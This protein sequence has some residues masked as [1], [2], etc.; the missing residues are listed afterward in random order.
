MS[1]SRLT[2][3]VADQPA[4]DHDVDQS[5]LDST[6]YRSAAKGKIDDFK[7]NKDLLL[8]QLLT[9]NKNTILHIHITSA[10]TDRKTDAQTQFVE[11]ILKLCPALLLQTNAKGETPLHLAARYGHRR[12]VEL[13][14]ERA[15]AG[16]ED[17][18]SGN[19]AAKEIIR[20]TNKE[21]DTALHEAVRFGH[22]QVVRILTKEDPDFSYSPYKSGETP[23]YIAAERGYR[24]LV[25]EILNNC[26]SPAT[27]GPNNRT[28]LHAVTI[29]GDKGKRDFPY[30]C[31]FFLFFFFLPPEKTCL[32][33]ENWCANC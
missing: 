3:G 9:P 15:K 19:Q 23:L 8:D 30:A 16:H 7:D 11:E 13:L 27:D 32:I 17:L 10:K 1:S 2:N 21:N 26:S 31:E 20:A 12:I 33:F 29:A 5:G 4:S 18:E 24:E 28:I 6:L 14:I 25:S 22:L